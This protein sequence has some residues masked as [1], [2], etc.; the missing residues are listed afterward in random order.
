MSY[1]IQLNISNC[2]T[3]NFTYNFNYNYTT[4]EDLLEY[5][6][7][8]YPNYNLCHCFKFFLDNNQNLISIKNE[9]KISSYSPQ[10]NNNS[11]NLLITKDKNI[12]SCNLSLKKSFKKTKNEIISDSDKINQLEQQIDNL[13]NEINNLK[14][15][16]ENKDLTINDLKEKIIVLQM[17][18]NNNYYNNFEIRN[19]QNFKT[20]CLDKISF[21]ILKE[22]DFKPAYNYYKKDDKLILR[23]EAPGNCSLISSFECIGEYKVIKISGIK[24]KDKEPK[25]LKENIFN[26]RQFGNFSLDIPLKSEEYLIKNEKP[27]IMSKLGVMII[28]YKLEEKNKTEKNTNNINEEDEFEKK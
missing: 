5:I 15:S 25:E 11:L 3:E 19:E 20:N 24:K 27:D 6:S 23:I 4:F 7:F 17:L 1:N 2:R 26:S 16:N 14:I 22:N 10:N 8:L 18:I 28:T 9:D 12:C 13:N 21:S